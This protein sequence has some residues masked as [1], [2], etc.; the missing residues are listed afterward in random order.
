MSGFGGGKFSTGRGL[1]GKSAGFPD[2]DFGK[3][4]GQ[5]VKDAW[6]VDC[7]LDA[8]VGAELALDFEP[9]YIRPIIKHLLCRPLNQ[10]NIHRFHFLRQFSQILL[11]TT[12]EFLYI[13]NVALLFSWEFIPIDSVH[14]KY[15][16]F[17]FA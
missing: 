17:Q 6:K 16:G 12:Y 14:D 13:L 10:L 11:N 4:F 1:A 15:Y 8:V 7:F 5:V 3:Y 2:T 9:K